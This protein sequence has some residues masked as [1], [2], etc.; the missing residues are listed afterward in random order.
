M[1]EPPPHDQSAA[2]HQWRLLPGML[3]DPVN[4]KE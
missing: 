3:E 1:R 4:L 2:V